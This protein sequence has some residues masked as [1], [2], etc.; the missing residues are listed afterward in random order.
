MATFK[1]EVK[2]SDGKI[3]SGTI[4]AKNETEARVRLRAENLTPVS[5]IQQG[6]K[7][8]IYRRVPLKDL[9]VFTRQFATLVTSGIQII[10]CLQMLAHASSC[11]PLRDTINQIVDDVNKGRTLANAMDEHPGAFDKLYRNL[12]RAGEQS[13]VLDVVLGRLAIYIEK[14]V[15]VRQK[16]Q[17]AMFYPAMIIFVAF[18]VISAIMVFVVP[19][20]KSMFSSQG[21]DL[22]EL[23]QIVVN[24]SEGFANYW[25][26]IL[27]GIFLVGFIIYHWAKTSG[28]K[29][30][31]DHFILGVPVLGGIVQKGAIA[32][33]SRTLSTLLA[34]GIPI[35]EGLEVSAKVVNNHDIEMAFMESKESITNGKTI[36][37]PLQKHKCIPNMVIQMISIGE[38]TGSL[39][40]MLGKVAD[41][42]EEEVDVAVSTMTTLI[43]PVLMVVLGVIIAFIVI[44]MYLPVFNMASTMGA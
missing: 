34:S 4:R 28:G 18:A 39:D 20:F 43:E 35:V 3:R 19:K 25:Y 16:V 22:P 40:S 11:E 26:V 41:F 37:Q 44:A 30:T 12:I 24:I 32:R 23:T 8:R 31:V 1:F 13:G 33:F 9:Q 7:A 29:K 15:K 17:S 14:S 42:F 36:A 27:M 6:G 10:Q 2:S 5:L 38:Q 21:K